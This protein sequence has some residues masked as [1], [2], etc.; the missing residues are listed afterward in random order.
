MVSDTDSDLGEME[1][2]EMRVDTDNI[3]PIEIRLY[4]T[5][6]HMGTLA[7]EAAGDVMEAEIIE[8]CTSPWKALNEIIEPLGYPTLLIDYMLALPGRSASTLQ[9][10]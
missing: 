1:T 4:S 3:L 8:C 6:L 2:V 7:Q 10:R 9:R 5:R